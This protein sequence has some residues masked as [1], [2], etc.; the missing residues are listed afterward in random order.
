MRSF[1]QQA[2][3]ATP[4]EIGKLLD[5]TVAAGWTADVVVKAS[6]PLL[7]EWLDSLDFSGSQ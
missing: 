2:T 3:T 7:E 5:D 4:P 6:I 1:F